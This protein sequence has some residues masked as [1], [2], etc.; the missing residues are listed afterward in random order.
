[1][2]KTFYDIMET[3]VKDIE[4]VDC[5][6][7]PFSMQC[8]LGT[9]IKSFKFDCCN[10]IIYRPNYD[11]NWYIIDCNRHLFTVTN[12]SYETR[13]PLCSGEI[14]KVLGDDLYY[15]PTIHGKPLEER[16]ATWTEAV[17][18]HISEDKAN[19]LKKLQAF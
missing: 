6:T 10:S 5:G 4:R 11:D 12:T 18:R 15:V 8:V 16:L 7:C 14:V 17:A 3:P 13:C 1:M 19:V 2:I 9:K